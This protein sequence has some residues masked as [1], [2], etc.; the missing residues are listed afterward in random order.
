M[1]TIAILAAAFFAAAPLA[2][3]D[4]VRP[5]TTAKPAVPDSV[6]RDT[7]G[8]R[9]RG[10]DPIRVDSAAPVIVDSANPTITPPVA[11]PPVV[12]P[13]APNAA[14]PDAAV[15]DAA[16]PPAEVP[17]VPDAAQADSAR[18]DSLELPK[19]DEPM[20]SDKPMDS[21]KPKNEPPAAAPDADVPA[22]SAGALPSGWSS[23][24]DETRELAGV[25]FATMGDGFHVTT[26]PAGIFYRAEDKVQNNFHAEA[27]L[28]QTKAPEHPEAY[29]LFFGGTG[30]EGTG[31]KYTYFLVRGD[32]QFTIKQR[33]A[34]IVNTVVDWTSNAAVAQADAEGKATNTLT[35]DAKGETITFGA[36]GQTLHTMDVRPDQVNGIVGL[37]VNHNLDV[38][39]DKFEVDDQ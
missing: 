8:G 9:A 23:R 32:G 12:D 31:Q 38:H 6:L 2:A 18:P 14:V 1:K 17:A 35:I 13:A 10:Q 36:N 24:G 20:N 39:V 3:Q 15:P 25:S 5:D 33:N 30:L 34:D 37:R 26:G 16:A 21:D 11:T 7:L 28:T 27:E 4:P 29:G 19:A 22:A